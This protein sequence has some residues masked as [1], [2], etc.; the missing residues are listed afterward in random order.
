MKCE[1]F[2]VIL[3]LTVEQVNQLSG[4][5]ALENAFQAK[6]G[7]ESHY[8]EIDVLS[9]AV[10]DLV[11]AH[12]MKYLEERKELFLLDMDD[13]QSEDDG[14]EGDVPTRNPS[15]EAAPDEEPE[16]LVAVRD[17]SGCPRT[18][19]FDVYYVVDWDGVILETVETNLYTEALEWR[20]MMAERLGVDSE[21]LDVMTAEE[22]ESEWGDGE[23]EEPETVSNAEE[24]ETL[25][26]VCDASGA[27]RE[28]TLDEAEEMR[29]AA[30]GIY[31]GQPPEPQL[32]E[33]RTD[34]Y[35]RLLGIADWPETPCTGDYGLSDCLAEPSEETLDFVNAFFAH[36]DAS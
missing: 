12:L 18:A 29:E 5:T 32:I 4:L 3:S 26:S 15:P 19:M 34:A 14:G 27:V 30:Q 16:T 10:A 11:E 28:V 9:S 13:A 6:R 20:D 8:L 25:V 17:A 24:P 2:K 7:I 35:F 23:E 1:R 21:K 36:E 22:Y 33:D 31:E